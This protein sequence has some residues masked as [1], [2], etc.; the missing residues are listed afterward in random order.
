MNRVAARRFGQRDNLFS[1]EI[2]IRA[3]AAQT[4][5]LVSLARV[6]RGSVVV[7]KNRHRAD[8]HLGGRANYSNRDLAAVGNQ[9]TVRNHV[10]S[11]LFSAR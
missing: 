1:V 5:S 2:R 4:A 11:S 9:K 8:T 7:R 6:Q 3:R 10:L